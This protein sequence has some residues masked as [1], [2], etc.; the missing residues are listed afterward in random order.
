VRGPGPRGGGFLHLARTFEQVRMGRVQRRVGR[1]R[2]RGQDR[3][4]DRQ[5]GTGAVGHPDRYRPVDLDHWGRVPAGEFAVQSGDL[6]PV[7]V[8]EAGR[9]NMNGDDCRLQLVRPRRAPG[10]RGVQHGGPLGDQRLIPP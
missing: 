2:P 5:P 6:H 9:L 8:G 7:G 10:H 4:Q 3:L 1:Q